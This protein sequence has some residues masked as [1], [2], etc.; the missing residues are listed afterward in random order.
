V[1]DWLGT[2]KRCGK[3][4]GQRE[5]PLGSACRA[6][7][8]VREGACRQDLVLPSQVPPWR[9]NTCYATQQN[10]PPLSSALR[11]RLCRGPPPSP[12]RQRSRGA[13]SRFPAAPRA[14]GALPPQLAGA[15]AWRRRR[16]P[17]RSCLVIRTRVPGGFRPLA[18][19]PRQSAGA[20]GRVCTDR[21]WAG[22]AGADP[23]ANQARAQSP[24]RPEPGGAAT[25]RRAPPAPW[26]SQVRDV[27]AKKWSP[28]SQAP[29]AL[30]E[31]R[32]CVCA[33]ARGGDPATALTALLET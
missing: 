9:G 17:C 1:L 27:E 31:S 24:W 3:S 2:E 26:G 28:G 4:R 21:S 14:P 25:G 10:F 32:V 30:R 22:A 16:Q 8:Q 18:G 6:F 7:P 33:F 15:A 13:H 12:G 23:G 19:G 20:G 11:V 29:G 5:L